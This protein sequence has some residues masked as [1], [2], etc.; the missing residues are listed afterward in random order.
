MIGRT[1]NDR[2]KDV[3][4]FDNNDVRL[5]LKYAI[6]RE[7][8]VKQILRGFGQ[9]DN[10]H[11]IGPNQR[12]FAS[13][14]PQRTFDPENARFHMK[15]AGMEGETLKMHVGDAAFAGAIDTAVLI[16]DQAAKAGIKIGVVREPDDGYWSN[17]WMK[18]P[19][20]ACYWGGRPTEDLSLVSIMLPMQPGMTVTG[21]TNTS[22]NCCWRRVPS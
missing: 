19:W 13:E 16:Q 5:A 1:K 4:P 18:K 11:P 21:N 8:L 22:T 15:K 14:L 12:Y 7:E 10:D 6:D 2:I 3:P 20:S 17:V 9:V